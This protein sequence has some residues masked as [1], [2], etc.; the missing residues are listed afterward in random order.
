[1]HNLEIHINK[2]SLTAIHCLE[3]LHPAACSLIYVTTDVIL[4][5]VLGVYVGN[6]LYSQSR[7]VMW[8]NI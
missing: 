4:F 7:T 2:L 1:M 6:C 5:L 8:L 3:F